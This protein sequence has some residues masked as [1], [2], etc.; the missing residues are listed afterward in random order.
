MFEGVRGP[1]TEQTMFDRFACDMPNESPATP[2]RVEP[3]EVHER[4]FFEENLALGGEGGPVVRIFGFKIPGQPAAF[5]NP[6][7]RFVEGNVVHSVV[8]VAKN[9]HT[10]HHHGIEPTNFNDGVGHTAFEVNSEYTYQFRPAIAGTYLYH[11]H[12][13]TV[14]H[15][16]MGMYGFMIVDPRKPAGTRGPE[17][18]YRDGGPGFVRRMN[19]IVPYD[20]EALW[21]VDEIDTRFHT[22]DHQAGQACP[23]FNVDENGEPTGATNPRMNDFRPDIFVISGIPIN[24]FDPKATDRQPITH[25]NVAVTMGVGQT[26][27]IRLLNAGYTIQR[28]TLGLDAEVIDVDG[29]PLGHAPESAMTRPFVIPANTP[30]ELSTARRYTMLVR[31]TQPG[32]FHFKAEHTDWHEFKGVIGVTET[33]IAVR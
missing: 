31:P 18:P 16:E 2:D 4:E 5:P 7:L 17:A 13:N 20:V 23:F 6:T 28:Y 21:A 29:R 24:N 22:L 14:L 9:T 25:P 27:L 33:I 10:I 30:F 12:K 15:F 11:C 26:L 32:V 8:K 3:D 19:D 1:V